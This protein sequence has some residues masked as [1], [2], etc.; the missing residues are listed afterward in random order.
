MVKTK[1]IIAYQV[2]DEWVY[3]I[4]LGVYLLHLLKMIGNVLPNKMVSKLYGF[5]VQGATRVSHIQNRTHFTKIIGVYLET[6][7]PGD[8]R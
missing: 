5:L 1:K 8:L 7:I 6:L 4:I 2:F 3:K